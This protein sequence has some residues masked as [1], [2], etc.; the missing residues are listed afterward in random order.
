MTSSHSH[1]KEELLQTCGTIALSL[2][3]WTSKNHFP[4]LG[5][6]AHWLFQHR[7]KVLEFQNMASMIY[8]SLQRQHGTSLPRFR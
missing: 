1:W 4:I 7:E 3:V 5:I 8:D 6:I 2:D